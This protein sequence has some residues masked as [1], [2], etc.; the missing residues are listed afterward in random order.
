MY[1]DDAGSAEY[2]WLAISAGERNQKWLGRRRATVPAAAASAAAVAVITDESARIRG[3][4]GGIQVEH[5]PSIIQPSRIARQCT[6]VSQKG[7]DES[8]T[9]LSMFLAF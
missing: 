8:V 7:E 3:I 2:S 5:C 6:G 9:P 1:D 4:D